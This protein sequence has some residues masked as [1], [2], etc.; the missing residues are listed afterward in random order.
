MKKVLFFLY[1]E[2]TRRKFGSGGTAVLFVCVLVVVFIQQ[3]IS[4]HFH[5]LF[6]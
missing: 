3:I 5:A 6:G 1:L 2:R 4:L